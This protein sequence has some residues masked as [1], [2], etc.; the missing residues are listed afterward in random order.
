MFKL[1]HV[2]PLVVTAAALFAAITLPAQADPSTRSEPKTNGAT[3][4]ESYH[5]PNDHAAMREAVTRARKTVRKFIDALEHPTPGETDF[6]V[7]KPFV[8][9]GE[10]EH[11]WLSD[12]KFIGGRFQGKIDNVPAK[13]SG[14][15]LGQLV[16]VNPDEI[17]DWAYVNDG[18]LVGGY[19]I[20]VHYN[21]LTP[22]Q[23]RE[24]DR[25][26]DFKLQ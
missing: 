22:E 8:D 24:F 4:P 12:V 9:K 25:S 14:P 1:T 2:N 13:I 15:K 23:K 19:T 26:A 5:V 21:E 7:K 17:S 16:S 11:I 3:E 10:I 6:E 20:R 18:T